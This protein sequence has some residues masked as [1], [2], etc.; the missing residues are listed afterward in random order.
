MG[1]DTAA[2]TISVLVVDDHQVVREG[3]CSL[4]S[5][6]PDLVVCGQARTGREAIELATQLA[7]QV[8]L[9]D[10]SMPDLNGPEAAREILA[11]R[12]GTRI[13]ALSMHADRRSV[14]RMLRAGCCGYL[15]KDTAFRE[16]ATAVRAAR[17]GE[18]HVSPAVNGVIV[19][20]Y[21][22]RVERTDRSEL[23]VLS[24]RE[25]EVLQG[26]AEGWSTKEIAHRMNVSVKTIETHRQ[27]IK[28]K[29]GAQSIAELT[30]VAIREGITTLDTRA[31]LP[32]A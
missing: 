12:P 27:N 6:E 23:E 30:K 2:P 3:L 8:V 29:L 31:K 10:L 11:A 24:L 22:S 15:L 5:G 20:E 1:R 21:L 32:S 4:L 7:P 25:R 28:E 14:T 19:Q 13:V 17:A 16:V 26:L 9:M 18:V